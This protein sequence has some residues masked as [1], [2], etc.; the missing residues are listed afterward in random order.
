MLKHTPL[1][2]LFV[3]AFLVGASAHAGGPL[4]HVYL[5]A[6]DKKLQPYRP[7]LIPHTPQNLHP[8]EVKK[9]GQIIGPAESISKL[10]DGIYLYLLTGKGYWAISPKY[11]AGFLNNKTF[12]HTYFYQ[13][14]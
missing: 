11:L 6:T 8:R 10:E 1:L 14:L 5:N 3:L 2:L 13:M 4:C 7:R 12:G 9:A